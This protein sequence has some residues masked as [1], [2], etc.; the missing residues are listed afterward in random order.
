[1][2]NLSATQQI[3]NYCKANPNTLF[4][5]ELM[6]G[7]VFQCSGFDSFRKYVSRAKEQSN[8]YELGKGVYYIGKNPTEEDIQR[9]IVDFCVDNNYG[10]LSG[11]P[12]LYK[13]RL[14]EY[15][16]SYVEIK[17]S[18][19]R[20]K[21]IGDNKI[22]PTKIMITKDNRSFRELL[23]ILNQQTKIECLENL[24]ILKELAKGYKDS[25]ITAHL[26]AEYNRIAFA[27]LMVLL[28]KEGIE[29]NIRNMLM[30]L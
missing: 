21:A 3:I 19:K 15:A 2:E 4:D 7:I 22:I 6:F 27:R 1:M 13:Y 24:E 26:L 16:P 14:I 30:G 29:N 12:L 5:V 28:N 9:A 8:L 11:L 20:N 25:Y 10:M 23:E 17:C 18:V